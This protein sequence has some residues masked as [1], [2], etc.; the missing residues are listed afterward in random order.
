[1]PCA[2]PS[3]F[4]AHGGGDSTVEVG[5]V[6]EAF[7]S[8]PNGTVSNGTVSKDW[9]SRGKTSKGKGASMRGTSAGSVLGASMGTCIGRSTGSKKSNGGRTSTAGWEKPGVECASRFAAATRGATSAKGDG[10]GE[11]VGSVRKLGGAELPRKLGGVELPPP[12]NEESIAPIAGTP[13]TSLRMPDSPVSA[14]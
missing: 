4:S 7:A 3:Q 6:F 10:V 12:P 5:D 14:T 13:S 2:G 11:V 8:V 9:A 1:M